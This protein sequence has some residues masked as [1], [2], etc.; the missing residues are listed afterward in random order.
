MQTKINLTGTSGAAI[1]LTVSPGDDTDGIIDL[2]QRSDKIGSWATGQ[3]WGISPSGQPVTADDKYFCGH[4][5]GGD[6]DPN[7]FPLWV[8][9]N[10]RRAYRKIKDRSVW[11][12]Y[13]DSAGKYQNFL[14][15]NIG[16]TVVPP[17]TAQP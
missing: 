4:K 1:E 2:L 6:V 5:A 3:G 11:Y 12:S 9:I 10:G 17:L 16:E 14:S 13:K 8:E 7:G 15:S